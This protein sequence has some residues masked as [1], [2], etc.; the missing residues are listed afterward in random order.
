MPASRI[1]PSLEVRGTDALLVIWMAATLQ[2][3][4][5]LTIATIYLSG[6]ETLL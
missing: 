2:Q 1:L 4:K 3:D 5:L 6:R